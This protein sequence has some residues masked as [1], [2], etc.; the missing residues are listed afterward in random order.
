MRIVRFGNDHFAAITGYG[1]CLHDNITICHVYF[2]ED[3]GHN[4]FSVGQLCDEDLEVA[5]CSNTCYVRDLKGVD[6]LTGAH[7]YNLYTISISD[8][9][10]SLPV[11]LM[12]KAT[13]TKSLLWHRRLSYMNFGTIDD[14]TKHDLVDDL[15]KFKYNK[16]HLCSAC[17]RGKSKKSSHPPKVVS[18]THSKLELLHM[19]ICGP[20]RV[21]SINRKK[22]ILMI[23]DDFSRFTWLY[24]L[25]TKYETPEVIKKCIA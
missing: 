4:L 10:A 2:I 9:A 14:L 17:E 25:H 6:L 13:S 19:E 23:I 7:E 1:D 16:D 15:S 20:M 5:F 11:R 22:Y 24:F 3:L 8:M 21:I 18:C 12:S